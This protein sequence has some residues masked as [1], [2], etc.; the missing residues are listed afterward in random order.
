MLE[1]ENSS[2]LGS[3]TNISFAGS[4]KTRHKCCFSSFKSFI[5]VK[6][7]GDE[8]NLLPIR[9]PVASISVRL[10]IFPGRIFQKSQSLIQ[11]NHRSGLPALRNMALD[12]FPDEPCSILAVDDTALAI[13]DISAEIL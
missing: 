9:P 6:L 4:A 8:A 12:P 10:E 3:Y 7:N 2:C 1:D 11:S 5:E 13:P